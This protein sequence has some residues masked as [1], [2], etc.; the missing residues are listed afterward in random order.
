MGKPYT[1]W[2][3]GDAHLLIDYGQIHSIASGVKAVL[4]KDLIIESKLPG[5]VDLIPSN[6][7]LLISFNPNQIDGDTLRT[8]V[9]RML[10]ENI[11]NREDIVIPS[12]VFELAVY[13]ND[14]W[15]REAIEE[16]CRNVKPKQNDIDF[17][18]EQNNLSGLDELIRYITTPQYIVTYLSMGPGLP[19]CVC[20]DPGY[21]LS[22]PKYNPPRTSTPPLS[23][24]MGGSNISLYSTSSPGGYQLF[25]MLAAPLLQLDQ[26]LPDFKESP[27]LT[28][29]GDRFRFRSVERDEFDEIRARCAEGT[30]RYTVD[31]DATFDLGAYEKQMAQ[32]QK[33]A[34]NG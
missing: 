12:R 25:G 6:T 11:E 13:F 29:V 32:K 34:K 7:S 20:M 9:V 1:I 10:D 27:V 16:Y 30:Y 5:I 33:G 22:V 21:V 8:E 18:I 2:M 4:L 17:I 26:R 19:S 31:R 3:C 15:T 23:I 28:R 24:G 14:P